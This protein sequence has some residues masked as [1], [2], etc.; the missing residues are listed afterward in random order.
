MSEWQS[1]AQD[2]M[3]AHP[4]LWSA[5][6]M[7]RRRSTDEDQTPAWVTQLVRL[8]APAVLGA[9]SAYFAATVALD[10]ADA[11]KTEQI[12]EIRDTLAEIRASTKE[13]H[14]RYDT[15]IVQHGAIL[16]TQADLKATVEKMQERRR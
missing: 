7:Q 3:A 10:K 14:D 15:I 9:L 5:L 11:V 2:F 8:A 1:F 16:G 4:V 13:L 12:K 6:T